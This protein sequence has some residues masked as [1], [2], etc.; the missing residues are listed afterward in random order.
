MSYFCATLIHMHICTT[1]IDGFTL[2]TICERNCTWQRIYCT[3][4]NFNLLC[5]YRKLTVHPLLSSALRLVLYFSV[6]RIYE[7]LRYMKTIGAREIFGKTETQVYIAML[8][9]D[10]TGSVLQGYL[11][12]NEILYCRGGRDTSCKIWRWKS[13]CNFKKIISLSTDG[14]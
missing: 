5:Q 13:I 1:V 7:M 6:A 10:C 9:C 12:W 14:Y 2:V 3:L 8:K 4:V 11:H